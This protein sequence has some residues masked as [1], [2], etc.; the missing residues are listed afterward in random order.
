MRGT[1]WTFWERGTALCL[2]NEG[3]DRLGVGSCGKR[4][5]GM[6]VRITEGLKKQA[7]EDREPGRPTGRSLPQGPS[8]IEEKEGRA[9]ED[10]GAHCLEQGQA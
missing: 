9:E 10:R 3:G 8:C 4:G 5:W 7:E 2:G 1:E 6:G